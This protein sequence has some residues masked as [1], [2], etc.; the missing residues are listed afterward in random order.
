MEPERTHDRRHGA[1]SG[2]KPRCQRI[3]L[4]GWALCAVICLLT[5]FNPIGQPAS[6]GSEPAFAAVGRLNVAGYRHRRQCTA[7][8]IAP[9]VALTAKHCLQAFNGSGGIA[10]ETVHLLLGYQRGAWREHH[11]I[12]AMI[13]PALPR[14]DADVVLLRLAVAS[15]LPPIPVSQ[16][17]IAAGT[18]VIQAGYGMDRAQVLSVDDDCLLI[19]PQPDGRWRHNCAATFGESGGPILAMVDRAW[20]V[21]A[22]ISGFVNDTKL[23]EPVVRMPPLTN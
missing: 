16:S 6:A 4:R 23:A 8:L 19:A 5:L 11:R 3:V 10:L 21:V 9:T 2:G 20:R 22:V 14:G 17:D 1:G 12:A 7:T 18:K 13:V 15:A